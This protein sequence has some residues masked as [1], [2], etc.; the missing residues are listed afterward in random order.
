VIIALELPLLAADFSDS[1]Q[2][3]V[4]DLTLRFA[5]GVAPNHG[6]F[7]RRDRRPQL[8]KIERVVAFPLVVG[9]IGA[10]LFDLNGRVLKQIWIALVIII[11][12]ERITTVVGDHPVLRQNPINLYFQ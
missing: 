8:M 9:A 2:I 3:L 1:S 5:V 4:P 11:S 6:P 12:V 7:A 10:D